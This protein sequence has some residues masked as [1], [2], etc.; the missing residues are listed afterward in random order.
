[1]ICA[2]YTSTGI[3]CVYCSR[4]VLH[5]LTTADP[6][7]ISTGQ[8]V[9]SKLT[10]YQNMGMFP[11]NYRRVR[12]GAEVTTARVLLLQGTTCDR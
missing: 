3:S 7:C 11:G 9:S 12:S 4:T 1:M 8:V 5:L 2:I 10:R 6:A